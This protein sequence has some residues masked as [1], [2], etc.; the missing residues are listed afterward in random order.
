VRDAGDEPAA[1]PGKCERCGYM[2]SQRV[3]KACL[4]LQSLNKGRAR[5]RVEVAPEE[6]KEKG[7]ERAKEEE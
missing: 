6:E 4:L 5:R 3:C 7:Q 1:P 2:S